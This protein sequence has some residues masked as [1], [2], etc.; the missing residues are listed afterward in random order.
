MSY[1]VTGGSGYIGS[2]VVEA[3]AKCTREPIIIIDNF[4]TGSRDNYKYLRDTYDNVY[5][6]ESNI[7]NLKDYVQKNSAEE[8][9]AVILTNSGLVYLESFIH[10][11]IHLAGSLSVEESVNNP[12]K[13]YENN[14]INSIK[15][16]DE[17]NELGV[18][19]FIFSSTAAVYGDHHNGIV[20]ESDLKIPINPYGYSK[21]L[22]E[23]YLTSKFRGKSSIL[24]YF[25]VCGLDENLINKN[26]SSVFSNIN[27]CLEN[28]ETFKIFGDTFNTHDG[29]CV[30]DYIHVKDLAKVHVKMVEYLDHPE[31]TSDIFN[32]G[33]GVGVSVKELVE[34]VNILTNNKLEYSIELPREG[35]PSMVIAVN[36][37]L[38]ENLKYL[39]LSI[40]FDYIN[41]KDLVISSIKGLK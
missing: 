38:V 5:L 40:D 8:N 28:S 33:Y 17:C 22:V 39:G 26:S 16:I 12:V 7:K 35:D 21:L 10:T 20:L 11:V 1:L 14:T 32:V 23:N 30:R 15:L 6:I 2:N 3:L 36:N 4:E 29:S 13:Y 27:K 9:L 25:N 18:E 19:K 31:S 41:V 34:E 37:K 24:R